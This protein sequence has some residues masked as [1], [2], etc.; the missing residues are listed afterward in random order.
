[1]SIYS[2]L[3]KNGAE[4]KRDKKNRL[5]IG[6]TSQKIRNEQLDLIC[7]ITDECLLAFYGC[8]FYGC[9]LAIL[10]NSIIKNVAVIYSEFDDQSLNSLISC[11]NINWIKLHDTKVTKKY[12]S[13][14][15]GGDRDIEIILS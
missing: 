5:M 6:F 1:M 10:S 2:V 12:V 7:D 11:E 15:L 8:D 9:D 14:V 4:V 13:D 3:E